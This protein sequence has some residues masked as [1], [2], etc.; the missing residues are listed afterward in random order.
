MS[1]AEEYIHMFLY[2]M[3]QRDKDYRQPHNTHRRVPSRK[4]L[5]LEERRGR[6]TSGESI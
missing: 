6:F 1:A 4:R 3:L 2:E 5:R